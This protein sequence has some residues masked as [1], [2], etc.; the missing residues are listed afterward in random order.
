MIVVQGTARVHPDDVTALRESVAIMVAA[1]RAESGCEAYGFAE[2]MLEPGL[3]HIA[4]RWR[5]DAALQAH[6]AT[7][8]MAA[9]NAALGKARILGVKVVAYT[10]SGERVLAG[11]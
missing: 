11:G 6:F 2:D 1:T 3:M 10:V 7:P 9:F 4:E 5:D 8:H